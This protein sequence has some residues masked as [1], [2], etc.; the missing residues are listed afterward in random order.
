MLLQQENKQFSLHIAEWGVSE[1]P[2][3]LEELDEGARP[4]K[5]S[6]C[7]SARL[8]N[9]WAAILPVVIIG[10]GW[11]LAFLDVNTGKKK[12]SLCCTYIHSE[13][14]ADKKGVNEEKVYVL[15][16]T[17]FMQCVVSLILPP[18]EEKCIPCLVS[19]SVSSSTF[20][21]KSLSLNTFQ[22][23]PSNRH[24]FAEYFSISEVLLI[25]LFNFC[26][27]STRISLSRLLQDCSA[28]QSGV[29]LDISLKRA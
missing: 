14:K 7:L 10:S 3:H 4:E 29:V 13:K 27:Q 28:C 9:S 22:F 12:V 6:L 11:G 5:R 15:S 21:C 8:K 2:C 24:W 18:P 16:D 17:A 20:S 25:E 26:P 23:W 19:V 1:L